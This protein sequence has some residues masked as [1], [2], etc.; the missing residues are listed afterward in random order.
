MRIR[1]YIVSKYIVGLKASVG[2]GAGS[3]SPVMPIPTPDG[4]FVLVPMFGDAAVLKVELATG[5]VVATYVVGVQPNSGCIKRDGSKAYV[6]NFGSDFISEINLLT[7]V[8]S[9]IAL[10]AGAGC[11]DCVLSVDETLLFAMNSTIN[12]VGRIV[13]APYAYTSI[14]VPGSPSVAATDPLGRWIVVAD[15]ASNVYKINPA[16]GLFTT[17]N[18]APNAGAFDVC[19][20]SQGK[21]AYIAYG[22]TANLATLELATDAIG[23]IA[24]GTIATSVAVSPDGTLL[25][26]DTGSSTST[27]VVRT[28]LPGHVVTNVN[29]G[30]GN[31][32]TN[33]AFIPGG[34]QAVGVYAH[35]PGK[36]H[37]LNNLAVAA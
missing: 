9:N 12:T 26:S 4:R 6:A 11:G 25:Y 32:I 22:F 16:T 18:M 15:F 24:T 3:H 13:L 21:S 29:I 7:N 23:A 34:R 31:D 14:V 20:D 28:T 1:D 33:F 10:P 5:L 35:S 37:I 8:V 27:L 17:V 2:L 30:A 19:I 36:L